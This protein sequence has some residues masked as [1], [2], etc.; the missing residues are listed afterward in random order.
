MA[1][2]LVTQINA[3]IAARMDE[4]KV[5]YAHVK[6]LHDRIVVVR[7]GSS[8][9]DWTAVEAATGAATGTGQTVNDDIEQ[10]IG[11][12]SSANDAA[13]NLDVNAT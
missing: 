1:V 10:I 13:S 5:A 9:T 2:G 6:R 11:Y 3:D 7:G 8:G 4:I 12:L